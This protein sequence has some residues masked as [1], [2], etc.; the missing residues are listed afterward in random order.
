MK[1]VRFE[2]NGQTACLG[3]SVKLASEHRRVNAADLTQTDWRSEIANSNTPVTPEAD[4]GVLATT[5]VSTPDG[6]RELGNLCIGD[7]V[8][9]HTGKVA[10][11][12]SLTEAAKSKAAIVLKAPY[13]GL[14]QDLVV[15]RSQAIILDGPAAEAQFGVDDVLMPAWALKDSRRAI[16]RELTRQD[17]LLQVKLDTGNACMVG[18]CAFAPKPRIGAEPV[19]LPLS[20]AEARGFSTCY[21]N[22]YF[23]N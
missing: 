13:F 17:Y 4:V 1:R 7:E 5:R 22:G 23:K 20:D 14:N 19:A 21:R 12:T 8:F 15:G 18:D 6:P 2:I 16:H 3:Q 11:V 10:K 9:D